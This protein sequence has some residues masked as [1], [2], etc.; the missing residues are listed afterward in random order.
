MKL[1]TQVFMSLT[2]AMLLRTLSTIG[3]YA[4]KSAAAARASFGRFESL[5][6]PLQEVVQ[7]S[8]L[9]NEDNRDRRDELAAEAEEIRKGKEEVDNTFADITS[10]YNA[11]R[12]VLEKTRKDYQDAMKNMPGDKWDSRAWEVYV[13][14]RPAEICR[15]TNE[16]ESVVVH[17]VVNNL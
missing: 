1:A 7:A 2:H 10:H 9:T 3:R 11:T 14:Q 4:N 17:F 6:V 13:S 8:I 15:R 12:R 16:V 5:Q